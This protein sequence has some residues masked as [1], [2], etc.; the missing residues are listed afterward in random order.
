[1]SGGF[2]DH[3]GTFTCRRDADCSDLFP[4]VVSRV[5]YVLTRRFIDTSNRVVSKEFGHA[6][7]IER[8]RTL[9]I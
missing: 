4:E 9:E 2:S 8:S 5:N 1:M 6:R 3:N 7:Y